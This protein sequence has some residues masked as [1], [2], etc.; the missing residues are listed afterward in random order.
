M[1]LKALRVDEGTFDEG[2][3]AFSLSAAEWLGLQVDVCP[4]PLNAELVTILVRIV[5]R[6]G[7]QA[8]RRNLG[9]LSAAFVRIN[10]ETIEFL[11]GHAPPVQYI[12]E[13]RRVAHWPRVWAENYLKAIVKIDVER[14]ELVLE[15]VVVGA[16]NKGEIYH[17]APSRP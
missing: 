17:R 15:V 16:I 13:S 11:P 10:I 12:A 2:P 6:P 3:C 4:L 7:R 1:L 14:R 5:R 9:M 8:A